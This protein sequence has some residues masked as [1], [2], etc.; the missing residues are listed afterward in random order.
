[1]KAEIKEN[2]LTEL[3]SSEYSNNITTCLDDEEREQ[4]NSLSKCSKITRIENFILTQKY[5]NKQDSTSLDNKFN[6]SS[7]YSPSERIEKMVK[8]YI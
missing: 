1:M 7:V 4:L 8:I 6:Q 3:E 2:K 5:S